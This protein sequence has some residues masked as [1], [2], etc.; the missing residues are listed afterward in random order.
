ML[1]ANGGD[2]KKFYGAADRLSHKSKKE[3]RELLKADLTSRHKNDP[4]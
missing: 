3:R 1:A 2:L 4:A